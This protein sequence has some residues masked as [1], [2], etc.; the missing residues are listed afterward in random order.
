[1]CTY[2]VRHVS[3]PTRLS[4]QL[5][6]CVRIL[7]TSMN[8]SVFPIGIALKIEVVECYTFK[9]IYNIYGLIESDD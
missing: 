6:G 5:L 2:H 3:G 9:R 1:M 4:P 7:F 8:E